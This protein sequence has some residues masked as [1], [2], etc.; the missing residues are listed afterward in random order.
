MIKGIDTP[1]QAS[2]NLAARVGL[3][4]FVLSAGTTGWLLIYAF[5][6]VKKAF[7]GGVAN[8]FLF[9]LCPYLA[10]GIVL[11]IA[12]RLIIKA[13]TSLVLS[14]AAVT[15]GLAGPVLYSDSMFV[16]P[17]PQGP[18]LFIV[19]PMV[20]LS[21]LFPTLALAWLFS[22]TKQKTHIGNVPVSITANARNP[23]WRLFKLLCLGMFT[24]PFVS[25]FCAVL[26]GYAE[27]WSGDPTPSRV[28]ATYALP[29]P[30]AAGLLQWYYWLVLF[31]PAFA[32]LLLGRPSYYVGILAAYVSIVVMYTPGT[33]TQRAGNL[34][35]TIDTIVLLLIVGY[36]YWGERRKEKD[37][38]SRTTGGG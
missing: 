22:G 25:G 21:L 20:Q 18:I 11:L 28:F 29:F 5:G 27:P 34:Y 2:I 35:L 4:L 23:M 13:R 6:G 1:Q 32:L 38:S 15:V 7:S 26:L 37:A 30:V 16:H 17:D 12:R 3:A 33:T 14:V 9:P 36:W 10:W 24:L 31:G 8:F 19:I